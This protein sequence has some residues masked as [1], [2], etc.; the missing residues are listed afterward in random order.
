MKLE[1][2]RELN[3]AWWKFKCKHP[4]GRKWQRLSEEERVVFKLV[5]FQVTLMSVLIILT[6]A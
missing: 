6:Y 4:L 1:M 5:G 2:I 3:V